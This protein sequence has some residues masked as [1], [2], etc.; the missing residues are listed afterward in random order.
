M[1]HIKSESQIKNSFEV[2]KSLGKIIAISNHPIS[3]T[4]VYKDGSL[5]IIKTYGVTFVSKKSIP[6]VL[7]KDPW[8]KFQVDLNNNILVMSDVDRFCHR[9]EEV[10]IY[11]ANDMVFHNKF[12][13]YF[14]F[15]GEWE[16]EIEII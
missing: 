10:Y 9:T 1:V 5:Y 2:L 13:I 4:V 16:S 14:P 6:E 11:Q 8:L 12:N 3:M 7:E 15:S